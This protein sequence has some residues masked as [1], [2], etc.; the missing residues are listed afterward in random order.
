MTH[1]TN[2]SEKGD[3]LLDFEESFA[4]E[5]RNSSPTAG[6]AVPQRPHQRN[7]ALLRRQPIQRRLDRE[8][9]REVLTDCMGKEKEEEKERERERERETGV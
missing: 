8:P 3:D 7:D 4:F 1:L 6:E 5:E 2:D 9:H